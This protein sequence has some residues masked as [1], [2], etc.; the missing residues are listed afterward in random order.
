MRSA[1]SVLK[2][3]RAAAGRAQWAPTGLCVSRAAS[4]SSQALRSGSSSGSLAAAAVCG[5]ALFTG[6]AHEAMA[7]TCSERTFIASRAVAMPGT[8]VQCMAASAEHTYNVV[9]VSAVKVK[10]DGV[11]RGLMA[12]IMKRFE[13]K[14]YKLVGGGSPQY[15]QL[16]NTHTQLVTSFATQLIISFATQLITA[17]IVGFLP[18][19]PL[20]TMSYM[21]LCTC[22]SDRTADGSGVG[23]KLVVPTADL[24]G[25]HYAE[26]N[27]KPFYPK[28]V[29]FLSSG[30]VLAMVWEGKEAIKY[31]RSM[32]GA[33]NPLASAPG[34]IRGDFG[35]DVG[36]NIVHGSDSVEVSGCWNCIGSALRS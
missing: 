10:P 8:T 1:G 23:I 19:A 6:F 20:A 29:N 22:S 12:E 32:I 27:G 13:A 3:L 28:L 17:V 4:T 15:T 14:G 16:V 35:V 33:T 31:G 26:H 18:Q 30:P 25:A 36:R 24:A 34:T 9:S 2:C 5:L 21:V 7:S 11:H